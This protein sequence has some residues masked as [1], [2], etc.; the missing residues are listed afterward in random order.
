MGEF[1]LTD[2]KI[3][4]KKTKNQKDKKNII[5]YEENVM[6]KKILTPKKIFHGQPRNI[7]FSFRWKVLTH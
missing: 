4:K 1:E 3:V 5:L 2:G 6:L 7:K